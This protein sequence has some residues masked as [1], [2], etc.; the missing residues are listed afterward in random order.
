MQRRVI[1]EL[2]DSDAGTSQEISASLADLRRI[3]QWF[4]G[5]RTTVSMLRRVASLTKRR[6]FSLLDVGAGSGDVAAAA[7]HFLAKR[8]IPVE[9]TLVDRNLR[10][11]PATGGEAGPGKRRR[12]R[13]RRIVADALALPFA[14]DSFD[15]VTCALLAHHLE[16]EHLRAFA[17][18]ALRVSRVALIINDLRRSFL[19]LALVYAGFPLFRSRLTRHDAPASVHRAYTPAELAPILHQSAPCRVEITR[20]YLFRVGAIVWKHP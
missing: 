18:E 4:G 11:L 17:A 1:P 5:T 3:N 15:L 13:H 16:P 10:H 7:Q 8:G 12:T 2:L 9:I 20:H 6:T 14:D 19:S